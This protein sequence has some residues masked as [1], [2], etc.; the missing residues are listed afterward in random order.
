M[1]A[2]WR[3]ERATIRD[4]HREICQDRELAY[5]TVAT[6]VERL[7][8]KKLLRRISRS[9]IHE[10][11]PTSTERQTLTAAMEESALFD[12]DLA[13]LVALLVKNKSRLTRE[14][15]AALEKLAKYFRRRPNA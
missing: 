14:D 15:I 7:A 12:D 3:K 9:R 10:Y 8:R 4:L 13:P 5:T 2:L 6:V 1:R 11:V